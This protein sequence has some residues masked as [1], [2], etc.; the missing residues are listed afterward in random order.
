MDNTSEYPLLA[1]DIAHKGVYL[2]EKN[3]SV[4]EVLEIMDNRKISAV[5]VEDI[6]DLDHYYLISHSDI[7]H[8]LVQ[9]KQHM[10]HLLD[11]KC[12][13][14]MR[15]PIEVISKDTPIDK[16][17]VLMHKTG[18]KRVVVGN[19]HGQPIGIVSTH[20][21][22]TWN[23]DLFPLGVPVLLCLMEKDS[24][25]IIAQ[26]LFK[27]QISEDLIDLLGGSLFAISSITSEVLAH[28]T[29][30]ILIEGEFYDLMIETNQNIT[31]VLV[32]T[33]SSI[34]FR[35][36]LQIFLR[37][38]MI[39]YKGDILLYKHVIADVSRYKIKDIAK[40]FD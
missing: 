32:V 18:Y 17:I 21:I 24:G 11:I 26:T 27:Q 38:F 25:L 20:D 23:N 39:R 35:R 14:V 9:H 19:A 29:N 12:H 6:D 16:V 3:N 40:I 8:Y 31:A 33:N 15:G 4:F 34:D 7:V 36:K 28:K 10:Q 2:V 13:A 1:S 5:V 30:L 22:I 37:N